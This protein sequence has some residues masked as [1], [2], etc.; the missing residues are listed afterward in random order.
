MKIEIL[1]YDPNLIDA[2]PY[3][4]R[5]HFEEGALNELAA[6]IRE[7]GIVQPL[8]A[9][10]S[11]TDP[12]RLE[13]VAGER[14]LRA[15]RLAG[16][17]TVPVIVHE[18]NDRQAQEIVLIENLQRSD[19]T[20]SEEARGYRKALDLRDD[21][22]KP[23]YTQESLAAKIGKP[24]SHVTDRLKLLLCPDFLITAVES[25]E[26]SLSTA[27]LVGRI[28]DPQERHKAA[29]RVL[30][31]TIQEVPLN[32]E[33]TREMIREEFMVSLQ[34]PGFDIEDEG[35]VPAVIEGGERVMGGA[36]LTC[37]FCVDAG[38]GENARSR[39]S[40]IGSDD[41]AGSSGA[42][43]RGAP[44]LL[45][46]LPKC[47]QK[48]QEAAWKIVRRQAEE[49]GM[50]VIE[51]DPAVK[52]FS[53]YGGN[54]VHDAPYVQLDDKPGY[55][56]IGQLAYENKKTYRSLLK[57]ADIEV[58]VAR[59]PQTGRRVEL[60]DRKVAATMVKAKLKN[61][62]PEKVIR[63]QDEAEAAK[64]EQR[65]QEIRKQKLEKIILHESVSDLQA[66]IDRKGL[67]VDDLGYVFQMA[68]D[69]SGADGMQFFKE[70]LELKMPKG[71]ASGVRDYESSIIETVSTKA[72][73]PQG[74]LSF[75]VVALLARQLRWSGSAG[76]DLQE[77]LQRMGVKPEEIE[78]R[79]EAILNA[80]TGGKKKM[81]DHQVA[82]VRHEFRFGEEDAFLTALMG[83]KIEKGFSHIFVLT[84][85]NESGAEGKKK[86]GSFIEIRIK[87][88]AAG[89][90]YAKW[91]WNYDGR[92]H[93]QWGVFVHSFSDRSFCV[94]AALGALRSE[95][96]K[97]AE[98]RLT[99]NKL[100][101]G[102]L[103]TSFCGTHN[104]LVH[105]YIHDTE[106]PTESA[107][108][109]AAQG[110]IDIP[111]AGEIDPKTADEGTQVH[112]IGAGEWTYAD[113]LGTSPKKGTPER[114]D[115]DR[116]RLRLMRLVKKQAA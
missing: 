42:L 61:T 67:G 34:K 7:H 69:N 109:G 96:E 94:A 20:V 70:W 76:E 57:K 107:D 88:D 5:E 22:G 82:P 32:Y 51:G 54:L 81:A 112:K 53:R 4:V 58:V 13:L 89:D 90:F 49:Q 12:A 52:L 64:K 31:P 25:R 93:G 115:Y 39:N 11:P 3:Q 47:Y 114:T 78:R 103:I 97:S 2:S 28:P 24:L 106:V 19:L 43:K 77:L 37:P 48:K 99:R 100:R 108:A 75:V 102:V 45:C 79:A 35:L 62:D 105:D 87:H 86:P 8:T 80:T 21:E 83:E 30:H 46:T 72:T 111:A 101:L 60:V 73:T 23:V 27:M 63:S 9:R 66:A 36:C 91:S 1:Q 110:Q 14:R 15:A 29:K 65:Q 116:R 55:D 26:V 98:P 59:H 71:T 41:A 44:H 16:L 6:S 95:F 38:S 50:R 18:L 17:E 92:S 74:W 68:L 40:E 10:E 104:L 84:M 113:C 33:Q 56:A 85:E